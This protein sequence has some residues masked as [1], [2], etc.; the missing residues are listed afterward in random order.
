MTFLRRF[1]SIF[2]WIITTLW[3]WPCW[4]NQLS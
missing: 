4:A 1:W 3:W 2:G